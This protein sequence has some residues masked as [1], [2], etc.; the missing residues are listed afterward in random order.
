ML[1]KMTDSGVKRQKNSVVGLSDLQIIDFEVSS[2]FQSKWGTGLPGQPWPDE[3]LEF[4]FRATKPYVIGDYQWTWPGI[5]VASQ[6]VIDLWNSYNVPLQLFKC[7]IVDENNYPISDKSYKAFRLLGLQEVIDVSRSEFKQN[8]SEYRNLV[9]SKAFLESSH[10]MALDAEMRTC[11][12]I[13]QELR[14]AIE[15]EGFS[16]FRFQPMDVL[17]WWVDS[18]SESST[19]SISIS[20]DKITQELSMEEQKDVEESIK[21]SL[22]YLQLIAD[23]PPITLVE[24]IA[25]AVEEI[26]HDNPIEDLKISASVKLGC[27]WGEQVRRHYQWRWRMVSLSTGGDVALAIVSEDNAYMVMPMSRIKDLIDN[28]HKPVNLLLLFNMLQKNSL[29]QP[30]V[31]NALVSIG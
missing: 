6:S 19:H 18:P 13:K 20:Q 14:D 31:P 1:Y 26:R 15:D 12:F 30:R 3:K 2:Q 17:E 28:P 29:P 7:T 27:L 8:S 16:G 4:T 10:V 21:A 25:N 22:A 24:L 11:I 5:H 9:A 23:T